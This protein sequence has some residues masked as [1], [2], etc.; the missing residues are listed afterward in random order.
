[1]DI[2]VTYLMLK[3]ELVRRIVIGLGT[4]MYCLRGSSAF[5]K[6]NASQNYGFAKMLEAYGAA[7]RLDGN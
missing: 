6:A 5:G 7:M 4:C 1:M 3:P 2:D